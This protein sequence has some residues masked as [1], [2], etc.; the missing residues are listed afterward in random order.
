MD[1]TAQNL[2]LFEGLE[3]ANVFKHFCRLSA[4]PR[5]PGSMQAVAMQM[6]PVTAIASWQAR[7]VK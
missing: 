1:V 3:P 5:V 6:P 2:A 4:V 7:G